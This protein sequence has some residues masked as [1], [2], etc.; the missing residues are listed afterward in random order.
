[1]ARLRFC[2]AVGHSNAI[3]TLECENSAANVTTDEPVLA[4][5]E[6]S[7]AAVFRLLSG[8][9]IPDVLRN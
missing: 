2:V 3:L 8:L 9:I 7:G 1:M 6:S 5:T 4:K